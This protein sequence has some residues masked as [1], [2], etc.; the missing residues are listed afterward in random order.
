MQISV[1][2]AEYSP[3]VG[4][5]T[6]WEYGFTIAVRIDEEGVVIQANKSGL[7]SLARH[8]LTL[9]QDTIPSGR[10]IHYD[11]FNSLEEGSNELIIE[12]M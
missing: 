10:H 8:L 9:S 4:I 12:K 11:E 1:E 7:I 5:R 2:V 3:E 6:E